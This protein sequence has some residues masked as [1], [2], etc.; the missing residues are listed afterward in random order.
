MPDS[1]PI[2]NQSADA[3]MAN[4]SNNI[5]CNENQNQ[6]QSVISPVKSSSKSNT[7]QSSYLSNISPSPSSFVTTCH[8]GTLVLRSNLRES[9]NASYTYE[10]AVLESLTN[11]NLP[12]SQPVFLSLLNK[13]PIIT[14]SPL[15][16]ITDGVLEREEFC[17]GYMYTKW[18]EIQDSFFA[19]H[20]ARFIQ[21]TQ[22]SI[23]PYSTSI[24][25]SKTKNHSKGKFKNKKLSMKSNKKS[26]NYNNEVDNNSSSDDSFNIETDDDQDYFSD[27]EDIQTRS[28]LKTSKP[29]QHYVEISSRHSNYTHSS[30]EYKSRSHYIDNSSND[31][32]GFSEPISPQP[33]Y[34]LFFPSR[35]CVFLKPLGPVMKLSTGEDCTVFSLPQNISNL[36]LFNEFILNNGSLSLEDFCKI[37]IQL[38]IAID[39]VHSQKVLL[40]SLNA[41]SI[42]ISPDDLR[43]WISDFKYATTIDECRPDNGINAARIVAE[44]NIESAY[45]SCIAPEYLKSTTIDYRTD[46]YCLGTI[47]YLALFGEHPY[48]KQGLQTMKAISEVNLE[49]PTSSPKL[50]KVPEKIREILKSLVALS[51]NDRYSTAFGVCSDINI[52]YHEM[53]KVKGD[54]NLI[55]EINF[56]SRI[57]DISPSLQFSEKMLGRDALLDRAESALEIA[58]HKTINSRVSYLLDVIGDNSVNVSVEF[59][60]DSKAFANNVDISLTN[61]SVTG[62]TRSLNIGKTK[63]IEIDCVSKASRTSDGG[64]ADEFYNV[65]QLIVIKGDTGMGKSAFITEL[66]RSKI[67]SEPR[68]IKITNNN[69]HGSNNNCDECDGLLSPAFHYPSNVEEV[70]LPIIAIAANSSMSNSTMYARLVILTRT[71]TFQLAYRTIFDSTRRHITDILNPIKTNLISLYP[72]TKALWEEQNIDTE[73]QSNHNNEDYLAFLQ[74]SN[75]S[76]SSHSGHKDENDND[77]QIAGELTRQDPVL[78]NFLAF[79]YAVGKFCPLIFVYDDI[80]LLLPSTVEVLLEIAKINREE[81]SHCSIIITSSNDK[82]RAGWQSLEKALTKIKQSKA[83]IEEIDLDPIPIPIVKDILCT[84][85]QAPKDKKYESILYEISRKISLKTRSNPFFVLE[86]L[87]SMNVTEGIV[88]DWMSHSWKFNIEKLNVMDVTHNVVSFLFTKLDSLL[89]NEKLVLWYITNF[90]SLVFKISI[91]K[92]FLSNL[93]NLENFPEKDFLDKSFEI[94]EKE[95]FIKK[96]SFEDE[97]MFSHEHIRSASEKIIVPVQRRNAILSIGIAL[98]NNVKLISDNTVQVINFLKLSHELISIIKNY[99]L[100][101][102]MESKAARQVFKLALNNLQ[103]IVGNDEY[104]PLIEVGYNTLPEY[105]ELWENPEIFEDSVFYTLSYAHAN[106]SV[107]DKEPERLED[108]VHLIKTILDNVTDS[109]HRARAN[110]SL[111]IILIVSGNLDTAYQNA[112]L[113]LKDFNWDAPDEVSDDMVTT[114]LDKA[115]VLIKEFNVIDWVADIQNINSFVFHTQLAMATTFTLTCVPSNKSLRSFVFSRIAVATLSK[116]NPMY[117]SPCGYISLLYLF[118]YY[119]KD[120]PKRYDIA[121]GILT[122]ARAY[123]DPTITCQALMIYACHFIHIREPPKWAA[124]YMEEAAAKAKTL[125]LTVLRADIY[126]HLVVLEQLSGINLNTLKT[127]IDERISDLDETAVFTNCKLPLHGLNYFIRILSV[128]EENN[129]TRALFEYISPTTDWTTKIPYGSYVSPLLSSSWLWLAFVS[130]FFINKYVEGLEICDKI[131][132]LDVFWQSCYWY[133]YLYF[134][135]ALSLAHIYIK[136]ENLDIDIADETNTYHIPEKYNSVEKIL[137]LVENCLNNL[138]KFD[139]CRNS[140]CLSLTVEG[141]VLLLKKNSAEASKKLSS[142][143]EKAEQLDVTY[144]LAILYELHGRIFWLENKPFLTIPMLQ[145]AAQRYGIYGAKYKTKTLAEEI[146]L[147]DPRMN[148]VSLQSYQHGNTRYHEPTINVDPWKKTDISDGN[149]SYVPLHHGNKFSTSGHSNKGLPALSV[150]DPFGNVDIISNVDDSMTNSSIDGKALD[151]HE[152]SSKDSFIGIMPTTSAR[153]P[154]TISPEHRSFRKVSNPDVSNRDGLGITGLENDYNYGFN[155]DVLSGRIHRSPDISVINSNSNNSALN[156]GVNYDRST[157]SDLNYFGKKKELDTLELND[158]LRAVQILTSEIEYRE[159]I[160][161][162]MHIIAKTSG[163]THAGLVLYNHKR[164]DFMVESMF[165]NGHDISSDDSGFS[166]DDISENEENEDNC[167][168]HQKYC[169]F[170]KNH[171]KNNNTDD[172]NE[173]DRHISKH[174]ANDTNTNEDL[175]FCTCE[176]SQI[177]KGSLHKNA[178]GT[179]FLKSRPL[180]KASNYISER[181]I[182]YVARSGKP[183]LLRNAVN[184]FMTSNDSYIRN[185]NVSS[186]LC[187]P[188]KHHKRKT[189]HGVIY[190]ENRRIIDAF[191]KKSIEILTLLC[192]QITISMEQAVLFRDLQSAKKNAEH[193]GKR[194]RLLLE[195]LPQIVWT[196][197]ISG[198]ICYGNKK[199]IDYIGYS[200]SENAENFFRKVIHPDDIELTLREY[201]SSVKNISSFTVEHRARGSDGTFRWFLTRCS[202]LSLQE[203]SKKVNYNNTD[204]IDDK[205]KVWLWLGTGT[206]IQDQKEAREWKRIER[207]LREAREAALNTAKLK[208]QFL[209]NMSHE[210][211]TPFSG[212]LGMINLLAET[213]LNDEQ[214]EYIS[215]AKQSCENLLFVID[216]IL[217]YSKL[218]AGMVK[219]EKVPTNLEVVVEQTCEL[220][221]TLAADRGIELYYY[222]SEPIPLVETDPHLIRQVLLNLAGNAIKFTHKGSVRLKT[223]IINEEDENVTILFEVIDTGIGLTNEESQALYKPFSQVD[224]STTRLYGGTGLGLSISKSIVNILPGS[225]GV[226]SEKNKGSNFWFT[227]KFRRL[228]GDSDPYT[229]MNSSLTANSNATTSAKTLTSDSF[230]YNQYD[231]MHSNPLTDRTDSMKDF[232]FN[233]KERN[234]VGSINNHS[235]LTA[236]SVSNTKPTSINSS[237]TVTNPLE[238]NSKIIDSLVNV[239]K[240]IEPSEPSAITKSIMTVDSI[241][242]D[243]T[244]ISLT[245]NILSTNMTDDIDTFDNEEDFEDFENRNI[246]SNRLEDFVTSPGPSAK[247]IYDETINDGDANNV[248]YVKRFRNGNDYKYIGNKIR[249]WNNWQINIDCVVAGIHQI[250]QIKHY[251]LVT[252]KNVLFNKYQD[253]IDNT[254]NKKQILEY[255]ITMI[256]LDDIEQIINCIN[257]LEDK[258]SE[259]HKLIERKRIEILNNLNSNDNMDSGIESINSNDNK[260]SKIFKESNPE[261]VEKMKNDVTFISN[262]TTN[263]NKHKKKEIKVFG[264]EVCVILCTPRLGKVL[265]TFLSNIKPLKYLQLIRVNKPLSSLKMARTLETVALVLSKSALGKNLLMSSLSSSATATATATPAATTIAT[266]NNSNNSN[267]KFITKNNYEN[268]EEMK[269]LDKLTKDYSDKIAQQDIKNQEGSERNSSSSQLNIHTIQNHLNHL[270]NYNIQNNEEDLL[271]SN[272][273]SIISNISNQIPNITNDLTN[274]ILPSKHNRRVAEAALKINDM[275]K[276]EPEDEILMLVKRLKVIVAEDNNIAAKVTIK[277]LQKLGIS[278]NNIIYCHDGQEA[279][280]MYCKCIEEFLNNNKGEDDEEIE[281]NVKKVRNKKTVDKQNIPINIILMDL[282]MPKKDGFEATLDIRRYEQETI[283][284]KYNY[285]VRTPIV[286]LTA[287]IQESVRSTCMNNGMDEYLVKPCNKDILG[288]IIF[289][290]CK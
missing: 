287:D 43:V 21:N 192:G 203:G 264:F 178:M 210:L 190:I 52:F 127:L 122:L 87:N 109:V 108:A 94:I 53:L 231:E 199:F 277:T 186:V 31:I 166:N 83:W 111:Y 234:S 187:L 243:I 67:V 32:S 174:D 74:E 270:N 273:N 236:T 73:N 114:Y 205:N 164:K 156:N 221:I 110:I 15:N 69:E 165:V 141:I 249:K 89:D 99:P 202:P 235:L 140:E 5:D 263:N 168:K 116:D 58:I 104:I 139:Y 18:I 289:K 255:G 75:I 132:E 6:N 92:E 262:S 78:S 20:H 28:I 121:T 209:A 80:D 253:F 240:R 24:L 77:L 81:L 245:D 93:L 181:I 219:Q 36:S 197:D 259:I 45:L 46:L 216:G 57:Y 272:R 98:T 59:C 286:G 246:I 225:I 42:L 86:L 233:Y 242:E 40:R 7:P 222:T 70:V 266:N 30:S 90:M 226:S 175:G 288:S 100:D 123:N 182:R 276:K 279:V 158:I 269:S 258:G 51:P 196:I 97:Y 283:S 271:F 26:N 106:F 176:R 285:N 119:F 212:V 220:L 160:P 12:I 169:N 224:G 76:Q 223:S 214:Q 149:S 157:P 14:D 130:S 213:I 218:E 95:G 173:D 248:K 239:D 128:G 278:N 131:I 103:S 257:C 159:F 206:D 184:D 232:S 191:S 62:S 228:A 79:V 148:K 125:G 247:T 63:H 22:S 56:E 265:T 211:R 153:F 155:A 138:N 172:N 260:A 17:S 107:A 195:M 64:G 281:T 2:S 11:N 61:N 71:I 48:K 112:M 25:N 37:A 126:S 183:L 88:Y 152:T 215:T 124:H 101:K 4:N 9:R 115:R 217:D 118:G 180:S 254:N 29:N 66:L 1:H 136:L 261:L 3:A 185:N 151:I 147:R 33:I 145:L 34:D 133:M 16:T 163:A 204:S 252:G 39:F 82:T 284:K 49:I 179:I 275:I 135:R 68:T 54:T 280:E 198:K 13:L 177:N 129:E 154:K 144:I 50:E 72:D 227:G 84:A 143:M 267:N 142:A 44:V 120:E 113:A 229:I 47:L 55:N 102:N 230:G 19:H 237:F 23:S 146:R 167:L 41:L 162:M 256:D 105:P 250:E 170:C 171:K 137:T 65:A 27:V 150:G 85:I 194:M 8:L 208:S 38:A 134:F 91:A 282:H 251:K 241:N 188:L 193:A 35:H 96:T 290:F 274:D 189:M 268:K 207:E 60:G 201:K 200:P 238:S 244:S 161:T 117:K 10:K